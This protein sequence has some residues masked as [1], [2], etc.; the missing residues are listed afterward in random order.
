MKT[1]RLPSRHQLIYGEDCATFFVETCTRLRHGEIGR[2]QCVKL[3][4]TIAS[5]A[6]PRGNGARLLDQRAH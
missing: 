4:H 3:I 6:K 2:D 5:R 1:R